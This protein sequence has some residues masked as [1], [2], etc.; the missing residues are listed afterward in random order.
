MAAL[1][2]GLLAALLALAPAGEKR[3]EFYEDGKLHKEYVVN[4]NEQK[5]GL[6]REYWPDGSD[7]VK[8]IYKVDQLHGKY[9]SWHQDGSEHVQTKYERGEPDGDWEENWPGGT[10]KFKAEYEESL[11]EGEARH[12]DEDGDLRRVEHYEGGLLHGPRQ[13]MQGGTVLSE[14]IWEGG[15]LVGLW[16]S[17]RLYPVPLDQLR[18]D[19]AGIAKQAEA[20]KPKTERRPGSRDDP[21]YATAKALAALRAVRRVAGVPWEAVVADELACT[22]AQAAV[23]LTARVGGIR[24]RPENPGLPEEEYKVALSALDHCLISQGW[25]WPEALDAWLHPPAGTSL[26]PRRLLLQPRYQLAGFGH[27]EDFASLWTLDSSAPPWNGEASF[28]PGNGWMPVELFPAD[29]AWSFELSPK[30]W[31]APHP[32]DLQVKLWQLDENYVRS[33]RPLSLGEVHSDRFMVWFTP[34][35]VR[36]QADYRYWVEVEG[37][38]DAAGEAA[39]FSYLVHFTTRQAPLVEELG[40]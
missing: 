3:Q 22:R 7:K 21:A 28:L 33:P 18:E 14:Q 23:E 2:I 35:G 6:Y 34:Q 20:A 13:V 27:E 38:V 37:L 10:P 16:G 24:M 40:G 17:K 8:T 36:P 1:R 29:G 26:E 39:E 15:A 12:W 5:H 11:L 25:G 31:S 9:E 32:E 30:H 4:A 19:L